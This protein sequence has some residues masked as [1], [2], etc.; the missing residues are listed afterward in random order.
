MK[1]FSNKP[2]FIPCNRA[3][4][5]LFDA[6]HSFFAHYILPRAQGNKRP[7]TFP[8]EGIIFFL[9]SLNPLRILESL[10]DSV[11][12]RE[13]GKYGGEAISRVGFGDCIFRAGLHEMKV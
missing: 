7:S 11:G 6:K 1:A 2:S 5:I 13:R 9:H 3:I 8:N 12:F 4:G 10:G